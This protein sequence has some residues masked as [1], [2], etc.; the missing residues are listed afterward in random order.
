MSKKKKG[1]FTRSQLECQFLWGDLRAVK[2]A[3]PPSKWVILDD[4][5]PGHRKLQLTPCTSLF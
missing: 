5:D 3:S 4:L 2:V 1:L